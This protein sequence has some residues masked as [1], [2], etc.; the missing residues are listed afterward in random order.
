[1][2]STLFK[3]LSLMCIFALMISFRTNYAAFIR[4]SKPDAVFRTHA[5][6][7]FTSTAIIKLSMPVKM[8][9]IMTLFV[10]FS[11]NMVEMLEQLNDGKSHGSWQNAKS[12]RK[13]PARD[14]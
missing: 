6:E 7:W 8:L 4:P 2:S 12:Q 9:H 1:M 10:H 11:N 3:E 13:D 14:D 5:S